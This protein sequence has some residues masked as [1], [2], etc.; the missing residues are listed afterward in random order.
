MA[1]GRLL[2]P[3][4][5]P[6]DLAGPAPLP[7]TVRG[8][9]AQ[10]GGLDALRAL[11]DRAEREGFATGG[12][13]AAAPAIIAEEEAVF[14][15]PVPD[16]VHFIGCGASY[17]QHLAEMGGVPVPEHPVLFLCSP[18]ALAGHRQT[19]QV[20]PHQ[21]DMVDYEGELA[22]VIGTGGY[23]I[24]EEDALG[25]VA[26]YLVH[27]D[28]SARNHVAEVQAVTV[29]IKMTDAWGRNCAAKQHPTFSP[30][31]PYLVTTDEI[32]DPQALHLTTR[33]NGKLVQDIGTDDLIFSVAQYIAYISQ[34]YTLQP[35]DIIST[36]TP[37][38]VGVAKK[39]PVFLRPNDVVEVSITGIGTLSNTIGRVQ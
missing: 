37:G 7:Q 12:V 9:L 19:I 15:A 17:H 14:A 29:P 11:A 38:G 21:A 26:G 23:R 30:M 27:N 1:S 31:G 24:R 34:W 3:S 4:L 25:H 8:I 10:P 18:V 32:P 39:P 6:A 22:A 33:V 16:P 36:G 2:I 20:P 13:A 28:L 35:G 5:L